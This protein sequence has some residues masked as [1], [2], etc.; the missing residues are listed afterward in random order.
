MNKDK[1]WKYEIIF[2]KNCRVVNVAE[3]LRNLLAGAD[4]R[5]NFSGGFAIIMI[6]V[7]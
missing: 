5:K 4:P 7:L 2:M 6:L 1:F 3:I